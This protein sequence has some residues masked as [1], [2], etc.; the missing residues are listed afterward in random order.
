MQGAGADVTLCWAGA[1]E[2]AGEVGKAPCPRSPA[3]VR[4]SL[5]LSAARA[6]NAGARTSQTRYKP[7]NNHPSGTDPSPGPLCWRAGVTRVSREANRSFLLSS[8][9]VQSLLLPALHHHL[10]GHSQTRRHDPAA[11]PCLFPGTPHPPFTLACS[12]HSTSLK[13]LLLHL[14]GNS[15]T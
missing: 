4:C 10:Q 11:Q 15:C 14:K 7:K 13:R 8:S 3:Q 9:R 2:G 1:R 12:S 6:A 5:Q